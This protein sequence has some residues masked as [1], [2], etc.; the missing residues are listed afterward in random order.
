M[1]ERVEEAFV[2]QERLTVIGT[3]L[4]PGEAAPEFCLD[5]LDLVDL[6]V[7]TV[8]LADSAGMVRLLSVVNSLNNPL[9]QHVTHRWESLCA[10]LPVHSCI[11]TISMDPPQIQARWQDSEEVLHQLLSASRSDQ[12]G[13][14]YG[15]WLAEW[16]QLARAV[17]VIDRRDRIAYTEYITDQSREPAYGAAMQA[18]QQ[19]AM[20]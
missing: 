8:G 10:D 4:Q 1:E 12:F 6:A 13:Q 16:Q 15:V 9:C 20:E 2:G 19:A 5:Y 17:F 11:Y 3:R 18:V 14:D 7:R